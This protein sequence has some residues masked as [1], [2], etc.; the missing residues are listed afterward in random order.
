M[1][2]LGINMGSP[3]SGVL[4][5]LQ[6]H[7]PR[8]LAHDEAASVLI[9]GNGASLGIRTVGQ[10]RQR[11]KPGNPHGSHRPLGAARQH[12][13]RITVLDGAKRLPDG[14]CT[15]GAGRHHIQA[16]SL[17]P[18]PNAYIARRH[19]GD[20]HGDHKGRN[21]VV[22][23][24]A[25]PPVG[26]PHR[27]KAADAAGEDDPA[28]VRLLPLPVQ[29]GVRRQL[30]DVGPLRPQQGVAAAVSRGVDENA[31]A[32]PDGDALPPVVPHQCL[33]VLLTHPLA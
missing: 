6:N 32:A 29:A 7:N 25:P 30:E 28:A 8:A 14:I 5:F 21:R 23:P 16:F 12:H 22:P 10:S 1:K 11:R 24:L 19:V 27:L 31:L 3:A 4:Q 2:N 17:Q 26:L 13:I 9:K 33:A 15:G 18:V 20:N